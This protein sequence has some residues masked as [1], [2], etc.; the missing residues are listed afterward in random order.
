VNS[1][2]VIFDLDGTLI[3]SEQVWRD[4]RRDLVTGFGL[5]WSDDAQLAMMGL[6]TTEW[7]RYMH[8]TLGVPLDQTAI[9]E[10]VIAEVADRLSREVP[11]IPGAAHALQALAAA[12][13]L[14]L[15]T[16]AAR[17][18]ADAVLG[19][20]G[21]GRYFEIV[22]SADEVERGKPAPNVYLRTLEL[23]EA[24]VRWSAAIEDSGNGIRSARA[25][26]LAVVAIPNRA[27][28]PGEGAL[29]LADRVLDGIGELTPKTI[30]SVLNASDRPRKAGLRDGG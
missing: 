1:S 21:W 12:Y 22:V 26:A 9:A 8:E 3:E 13:P 23:M 30:A 10:H 15:A 18:V 2:C 27:F 25:A 6:R 5:R 14:G 4:V 24:D 20:A 29:L 17:P 16:S 11:I 7:S 28:P 19:A